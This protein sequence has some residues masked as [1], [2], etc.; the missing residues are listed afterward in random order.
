MPLSVAQLAQLSDALARE[1]AKAP[2]VIGDR[3]R[4][5]A[6]GVYFTPPPLIEL[7]VDEVLSAWTAS[8]PLTL[9]GHGVP[10]VRVLDPACG[11]G[12]FLAG[13]TDALVARARAEVD[14]DRARNAILRDSIIGFERD[15]ELCEMARRRLP[16]ARIHCVEAL[17]D[18]PMIEPVD[19]VVGNPP[20]VRSIRL[21]EADFALRERLRGKLAATSLGE[22]D[23]YGAFLEQALAWTAPGGEIGLVVPSRWLTAAFA[24]P[25]RAHLA[26]LRSVRGIVDF[27]ADQVFP[28][29]TTYASV[30][31]LTRTPTSR[32]AVARRSR[33]SW[34]LGHID[35][36]SLGEAPWRLSTGR[37]LAVIDRMRGR[38]P[39]LGNIARIVKGAGTNADPVY[40]LESARKDGDLI[41]GRSRAR[42]A[43]VAV[44]A[45]ICPVCIR[46]RDVRAFAAPDA[47]VRCIVPYDANGALIP[48]AEFLARYPR[49]A[50][51]LASTRALLDARERG[52]FQGETFYR[53]GR[54]QNLAFHAAREPKIVI[55]DVARGGRAMIDVAGAL[56]LDS[57]YA[58][59]LVA[60][61]EI[62]LAVVWAVLGSLAPA[63]WLSHTGILL[64]GG[65][66][67]MKTAY[68]RSLPIPAPCAATRTI[69]KLATRGEDAWSFRAAPADIDDLVRRA[70]GVSPGDWTI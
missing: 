40:V 27:G 45:A 10:N 65:Y 44:E 69:E 29:A 33:T 16:G 18:G 1:S 62:S 70:Y 37:P 24:A 30:A 26:R 34:T 42:S 23:L 38:G 49:A 3:G 14:P 35:S 9:D 63:L 66:V 54:P 58:V 11:D 43:D 68:L 21:G 36:G 53:F 22:W 48:P 20:Y 13:A 4:R 51:Y 28:G 32:V 55:P 46:G 15:P 50:E 17:C 7:V 47:S 6:N 59:R 41:M 67:R 2:R 19:L 60:G 39:E 52:R 25:L 8:R 31:F 61:A 56:V 57:A 64:R 12:R 5:R